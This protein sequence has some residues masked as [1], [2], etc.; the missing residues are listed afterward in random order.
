[1]APFY[2]YAAFYAHALI[3]LARGGGEQPYSRLVLKR[4]PG[5]YR[6]T[7]MTTATDKTGGNPLDHADL[8]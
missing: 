6:Y 7:C 3:L 4:D 1:M 8:C 5:N 2:D